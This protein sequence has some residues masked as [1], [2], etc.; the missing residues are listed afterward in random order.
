MYACQTAEMLKDAQRRSR[1]RT[2]AGHRC[3][4]LFFTGLFGCMGAKIMN[5]HHGIALPVAVAPGSYVESEYASPYY[6]I[7]RIDLVE[8]E[9][10]YE[11]KR[12][13]FRKTQVA[14]FSYSMNFPIR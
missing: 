10:L 6:E 3:V 7:N 12:H 9:S 5:G 14:T 2:R 1:V 4:T 13:H 11:K 8:D